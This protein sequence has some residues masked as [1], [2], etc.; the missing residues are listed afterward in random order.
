MFVGYE[1]LD[2]QIVN[3]VNDDAVASFGNVLR[4]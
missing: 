4:P 2:F 1:R 3:T